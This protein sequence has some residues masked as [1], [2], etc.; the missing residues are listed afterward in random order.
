MQGKKSVTEITHKE[1]NK[2]L[3]SFKEPKFMQETKK[4]LTGAEKGTLMHLIMQK[5]DFKK[6]YTVSTLKDFIQEL[7]AKNIITTEEEKYI[8][9]DKI[10]KFCNSSIYLELKEA[11]QIVK[12]QPFYIYL[13]SDEI[14]NTSE[15]EQILVQGI[16]DLYYI[17]KN[18]ELVLLDYKTDYIN[19]EQELIDKYKEQL[20]IYR[21]ALEKSLNKKV[22]KTYIY[23]LHLNKEINCNI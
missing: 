18:D 9:I 1:S 15:K 17:N 21:I 16:I 23:S 6:E 11:K 22:T 20:K 5:L 4:G 13:N 2:V 10:I 3:E 14:Y 8:D 19:T 12:E 7:I